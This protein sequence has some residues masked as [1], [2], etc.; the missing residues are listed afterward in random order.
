MTPKVVSVIP[1]A[2]AN[3]SAT[4]GSALPDSIAVRVVDELGNGVVGAP[5]Q[6][7]TTAAGGSA[8][9]STATS[10][11]GGVARTRWTLG[12]QAGVQTLEIRAGGTAVSPL[13]I[14][15]TALVAPPAQVQ[16]TS[17]DQ[18]TAT[19]GSQVPLVVVVV[20]QFGNPAVGIAVSWQVAAGG[21][22]VTPAT[23]LSDASGRAQAQWTLGVAGDNRVNASVSTSVAAM[24][25]ATATQAPVS[26]V[27]IALH[28]PTIVLGQQLTLVTT[29]RDAAGNELTDRSVSFQSA[30]TAV[31]TV[32]GAGVV[33]SVSEGQTLITASSE[34]VSDQALVTVTSLVPAAPAAPSLLTASAASSSQ[35]QLTWQDNSSTESAFQVESQAAGATTWTTLATLVPNTTQYSHTNLTPATTYGYRIRA[36]SNAVCSA[37]SSTVSA[38]TASAGSGSAPSVTTDRAL[39]VSRDP[40]GGPDVATVTAQAIPNGLPTATWVEWGTSP[41]LAGAASTSPKDAGAGTAPFANWDQL[42]GLAQATTYYYRGVAQNSAGTVRGAI[43][44]FVTDRP[45]APQVQVALTATGLGVAV[46]WTHAGEN[47]TTSYQV[48]RREGTTTVAVPGAYYDYSPL[49]SSAD[50][51]YALNTSHASFYTV[52]ACNFIGCASAEA[53]ITTPPLAAPSGVT[54]TGTTATTVSLSWTDNAANETGYVVFRR[55]AGQPTGTS[56][57]RV[58]A[59]VTS[60]TDDGAQ[61]EAPPPVAGTTYY[62]TVA[63]KG[64]QANDP[65]NYSAPSSEVQAVAGGIGGGSLPSVTTDRALAVSRDPMGG[66]DVATVTAQAIPNGLPTAT[67]VEW[68]TSPTLAGAASTSPKDAGAGTAPFANW[69]QLNGLAQATTYYYRGVAQNSAGTVRGAILSFVTD[70]PSA[71]QVQVALTATGLGVAVTWTHAGENGTTSYQVKRREGTT[72]VAV[73]GAYYDYSPLRSS[74]DSSYALN[75]SHASFYTVVACNFIGCASAEASITTPP[76]AA[77][78]GVTVTGTT[79]TTVSLSWTDNAANETGYWVYRR[80]V[81]QAGTQLVGRL[82]ANVTSFTDNGTGMPGPGQPPAPVAGVTYYYFVVAQ[83]RSTTIYNANNYS[84]PSS[85]VQA[86]P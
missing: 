79:A 74:A 1:V 51:S 85:E 10:G 84:A 41:T 22:S 16:K 59:N 43:L 9:P 63:A 40:M 38:T 14:Q 20:D 8:S 58:G 23:S 44:S 26:S 64:R 73:P 37:Y 60:F 42:N 77:P 31:A 18:T 75:T 50:S 82:G 78:S 12:T 49:R 13:I 29:V 3:G 70:R 52:V 30:N 32:S 48:K 25:T 34:G 55:T 2:A 45:S 33:Q 76:L 47:G 39:A 19:A 24:F 27:T 6:F 4:V 67:W 35:I 5:V 46:T 54:V 69:D 57:G 66:P 62:Y 71:P 15:A 36:C 21:G 28:A 56:V 65:T 72:T 81:G 86:V 83:G 53:S 68:G 17:G 61:H 80:Q 11:A 7:A